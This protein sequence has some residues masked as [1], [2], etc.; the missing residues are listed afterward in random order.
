M[1][2]DNMSALR[3]NWDAPLLISPHNHNRLYFAANQLLEVKIK[4]MNGNV[5]AQIYLEI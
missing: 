1:A 4:V 3:W 5:L 2:D